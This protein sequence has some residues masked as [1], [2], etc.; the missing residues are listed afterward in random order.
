MITQR[1]RRIYF[2]RVGGSEAKS[3]RNMRAIR[4]SDEVRPKVLQWKRLRCQAQEHWPAP[5]S[6]EIRDA[7]G[8]D[9]KCRALHLSE[10]E[11]FR[12]AQECD[13]AGRSIAPRGPT[14][15]K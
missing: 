10:P 6:R 13:V 11:P 12:P 9:C 4:A 2:I 7:R 3:I 1:S 5:K 8:M 14:K 15:C